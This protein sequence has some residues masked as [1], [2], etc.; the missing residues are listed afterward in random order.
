MVQS[1]YTG[2]MNT[3]VL[4]S[5]HEG[6]EVYDLQDNRLGKVEDLYFGAEADDNQE[7]G[8]GVVTAPNPDLRD[9]S[10]IDDVARVFVGLDDMPEVIKARLRREGFIKVGAT[11]LFAW[12]RY[13]LPEQ[14][15]RVDEH[16]HLNVRGDELIRPK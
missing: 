15:A 11:G 10:L 3:N 16:V 12:A 9:D 8:T 4:S 6:M 7:A 1:R 14:I 2:K 5:I 13:I